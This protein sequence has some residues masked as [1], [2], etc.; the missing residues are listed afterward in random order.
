MTD[1][2]IEQSRSLYNIANWSGGYFDIGGN[3]HLLVRGGPPGH[4]GVDLAALVRELPAEGVGLPVLMRFPH[5]LRDRVERLSGAFD[6]ACRDTGY[7]GGYTAVYPI[8][9]NQQRSVVEGI[10]DAGGARVGLEAGSKPELMA[11]LAMAPPGG[12]IVCNGY[13]DRE[14]LRLAHIGRLL[15]QRIYIVVEK[16]SE[17]DGIIE[18]SRSLGVRPLLGMRVRLASIGK[19]KWQNTGGEK[20]KFGLSAAQVLAL[21]DR[22]R[23]EG[24]LDCMQLLHFHMGS[25][26][27]NIRD[28]HAGMREAARYYAELREL[29]ADIRVVD[30]G[31][32]LGVDYDGT[33]SRGSCSMNYSVQEYANNIVRTLAN[34][35]LELDLPHPDIFSES[36]RALTAH[37]AVLVTNVIDTECA[38]GDG[39]AAPP[40]DDAPQILLD[41]WRLYRNEDGLPPTEICHDAAH[42]L[43]E[44]Q[45]MYTHGLL[46]LEERAVAERL[47]FAICRRLATDGERLPRDLR[48]ELNEKLADKYFCN[49]SLF[50]SIPDVWGIDQIFPIT[51]LA[52]LDERPDRRGIVQDLTCDSDG[53]IDRYVDGGGVES[54]LPLHA[55]RAG[56]PYLL[57][58]FLVGAYQEILGDLHN[59]FG[60]ADSINVELTPDGGYRLVDPECGDTVGELLRYVHYDPEDLAV[61]YR[62]KAD[63]ADL[64]DGLRET[65]LAELDAGLDGYTYLE[66]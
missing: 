58:I 13:K 27:A 45:T 5:I 7:E 31:G 63:A 14:Y 16:P 34:A 41:L 47:Y 54:T 36:G 37:H 1:W 43:N 24:M 25:Q 46:V 53:R 52:R 18:A 22:L 60:D 2:T 51:P 39:E 42:W 15:G 56:E 8:K 61:R 44:A 3:G 12:V 49:F 65:V 21:L 6:R 40:P 38:P 10:L 62:E 55:P 4:P 11:V 30:V 9:V 48:D 35:C 17:I 32:G 66:E 57:G 29:G 26:I 64:D 20:A 59:L 50:Q 19:G 33:R 28:I 23:D